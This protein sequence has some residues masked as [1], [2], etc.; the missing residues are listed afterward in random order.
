MYLR[1][2][3]RV[4]HMQPYFEFVRVARRF[5][6]SSSLEG[7]VHGGQLFNSLSISRFFSRV[8]WAG[9]KGQVTTAVELVVRPPS[10]RYGLFS[11]LH[12]EHLTAW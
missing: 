6:F 9:G 3:T 11:T 10:R 5:E 4:K 2:S 12:Q 1:V 7:V 8:Q